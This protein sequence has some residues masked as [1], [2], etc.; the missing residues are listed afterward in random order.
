MKSFPDK[1]L[2]QLTKY[3]L[4]IIAVTILMIVAV[5]RFSVILSLLS[6]LIKVLSPIIW[7]LAIAYILNPVMLALEKLMN[8]LFFKK[9]P[10]KKAARR[11]SVAFTTILT[12]S[13]IIYLLYM[14]LPEISR[15]VIA[16]PSKISPAITNMQNWAND[17]LKNYPEI[18]NFLDKQ[19]ASLNSDLDSIATDLVAKITAYVPE[20]SKS[21]FDIIISLK[22]F[23]LGIIVSVYLL[24]SKE[25]LIAQTK[26]VFFAMFSK[27]ACKKMSVL[28]HSSNKMFS[29]FISGKII[30]SIIIGILAFIVMKIMNMPYLVLISV[31]IGVTNIIP[32]FGPF[33]GAIPSAFLVLI[34]S[35]K[36]LIPF[37]IFIFILQQFDGNILGPRIL[38]DSTGLPAFWVLFAIFLGGGLFGFAGMLLGVPTF[39]VIYAVFRTYIESRLKIK[40]LPVSTN[41][42]KGNVEKYYTVVRAGDIENEEET[43]TISEPET[44]QKA[45]KLTEKENKAK[46]DKISGYRKFLENFKPHKK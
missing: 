32:F 21:I 13:A 41:D 1:N 35:P 20:V 36:K 27:N 31:I 12:I 8:K 25:T 44:T 15:S 24:L 29:G 5:F 30:D 37:I 17:F 7:G 18:N 34:D 39:A 42:Y 6:K 11:L 4:L 33:I 9:K 23:V 45:E 28:Y 40:K 26:K 14:V 19:L 10:H 2:N 22:D 46:T 16:I 38:G 43:D 3:I